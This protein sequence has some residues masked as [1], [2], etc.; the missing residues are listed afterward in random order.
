MISIELHILY[1]H[2]KYSSVGLLPCSLIMHIEMVWCEC[3][4]IVA[5]STLFIGKPTEHVCT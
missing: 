2:V 4:I 1:I 3:E 5:V